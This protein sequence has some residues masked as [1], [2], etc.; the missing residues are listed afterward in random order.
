MP[1]NEGDLQSVPGRVSGTWGALESPDHAWGSA[2]T[3]YFKAKK[4]GDA[5]FSVENLVLTNVSGSLISLGSVPAPC[6]VQ[7]TRQ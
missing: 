4:M 1:W 5:L 6:T 3:F 7:I 2:A